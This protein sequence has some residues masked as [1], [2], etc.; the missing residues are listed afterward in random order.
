MSSRTLRAL[1]VAATA[2]LTAGALTACGGDDGAG[3]DRHDE[4][5]RREC[6][7]RNVGKIALERGRGR[8]SHVIDQ[9]GVAVGVGAHHAASA[10]GAART[11][12]IL[13]R[14]LLAENF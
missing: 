3:D 8:E 4:A 14:D 13:D 12:G 9:Q 2:L 6:R 7:L 1:A 10:D 5:D 11:A